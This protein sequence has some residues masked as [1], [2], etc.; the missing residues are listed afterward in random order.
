MRP[1]AIA[2]SVFGAV[3][4]L[5]DDPRGMD[6]FDLSM[7]G[8]VWSF[9]AVALVLPPY[10]L[11]VAIQ[12]M[13]APRELAPA[14]VVVRMIVYLVQW[15]AFVLTS[16]LLA[17]V[18]RR[19]AYF[20]P[21]VVAANWAALVQIA[22]VLAV[23]LVTTVL[24]PALD[25]LMLMALTLGLLLYD[26]RVVRIAFAAPGFDGVAVVAIQFMV[27]RLVQRLAAP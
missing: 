27:S 10:A 26:Y 22:I 20:V 5:K 17:R 8:F 13:E 12:S 2:A 24:P 18:L 16:A 11:A 6:A 15:V 23:V 14:P 25:G 7:R 4:L 19:E 3:L 9:L 21:Y 1:N